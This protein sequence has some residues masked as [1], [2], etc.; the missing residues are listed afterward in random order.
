MPAFSRTTGSSALTDLSFKKIAAQIVGL[1]RNIVVHE[2]PF[3][4]A[5]SVYVLKGQDG[6]TIVKTC[7]IL[8]REVMNEDQAAWDALGEEY[9]QRLGKEVENFVTWVCEYIT[10]FENGDWEGVVKANATII[11]WGV[12]GQ[13]PMGF[14]FKNAVLA[15]KY[16]V[17][18]E[19]SDCKHFPQV[20]IPEKLAEWIKTCCE[21]AEAD[22][23][24][25]GSWD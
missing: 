18:V 12:G 9:H 23:C 13:M 17:Q 19:L 14:F 2:V 8:F 24:F 4:G 25:T 10:V 5:P 11:S 15:T 1:V 7:K 22:C 6:E 16:E 21:K 3:D 20:S